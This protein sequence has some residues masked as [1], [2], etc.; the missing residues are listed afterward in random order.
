MPVSISDVARRAEVSITTVSH[1]LSGKRPVSD[2]AKQRITRA[3]AELDYVPGASARNLREGRTRM[4]A[5]IVPEIGNHFFGQLARG[6]ED[7]ANARDHGLVLCN[8]GG[9]PQRERRYL[10]LLRG[11]TVDG[12]VYV[13]G[14]YAPPGGQLQ[15][16][17][18]RHEVVLADE[19]T[20]GLDGIPLV[21]AD[22]LSGGRMIGELFRELG[23]EHALVITGPRGLRSVEDRLRGFAAV[24]PQAVVREGDFTEAA[25]SGW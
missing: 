1:A 19:F 7:A 20:P 15:A 9:S 14:S 6:A 24:Y 25:G 5:L 16:A 11:R 12:V 2:D 18:G 23:H 22:N 21:T 3:I 8:S 4:I 13:A 17:A 10:E